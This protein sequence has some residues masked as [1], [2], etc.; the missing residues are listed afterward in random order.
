MKT[1]G[2]PTIDKS[3]YLRHNSRVLYPTIN[4]EYYRR[5]MELMEYY[6]RVYPEG[7]RPTWNNHTADLR[8][9]LR[10]SWRKFRITHEEDEEKEEKKKD[11]GHTIRHRLVTQVYF[12][13]LH[14]I[15]YSVYPEQVR[16]K[17]YL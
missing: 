7:I 17:K 14:C 2:A 15:P 13:V 8:N 6:K 1:I 5:K 16:I 11:L 9:H 12:D 3:T 10:Y 4:K